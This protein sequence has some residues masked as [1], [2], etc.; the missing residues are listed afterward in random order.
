MYVHTYLRVTK[1]LSLASDRSNQIWAADFDKTLWKLPITP[2]C[3]CPICISVNV[4]ILNLD[5]LVSEI[6]EL[7]NKIR[8]LHIF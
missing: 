7:H 1:S 3:N 6:Y 2:E 8:F 4:I 5:P